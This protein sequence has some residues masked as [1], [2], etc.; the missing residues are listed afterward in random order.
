MGFIKN[1]TNQKLQ[2]PFPGAT[3]EVSGTVPVSQCNEA[4]I[5]SKVGFTSPPTNELRDATSPFVGFDL[6]N[7]TLWVTS[8]AGFPPDDYHIN[9]NTDNTL[10]IAYF[11]AFFQNIHYY[12][13]DGPGFTFQRDINSFAQFITAA[14][15]SYTIKGA[16]LFT[17]MPE[18]LLQE[19]CTIN[20]NPL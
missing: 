13:T 20:W 2:E 10:F 16:K 9:N 1:I 19:A 18:N 14:G 12:I 4:V 6:T 17:D 3:F 5:S 8:P 11:P 7:K 15:Y